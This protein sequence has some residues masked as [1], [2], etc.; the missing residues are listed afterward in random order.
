MHSSEPFRKEKVS[1]F[2]ALSWQEQ[3]HAAA[4]AKTK[5]R[6]SIIMMSGMGMEGVMDHMQEPLTRM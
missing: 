4:Y 3:K 5:R 6:V 1:S 2:A